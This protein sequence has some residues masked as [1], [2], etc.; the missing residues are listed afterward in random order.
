MRNVYT[1]CAITLLVLEST[2]GDVLISRA[3][4]KI[5]DLHELHARAGLWAVIKAILGS[6]TFLAGISCMALAFFS[7]LFAL[8][9]ADVSLVAPASAS[10]TFITNAVS[11]KS[12]LKERVDGRRWAAALCV[13][14]GVALLAS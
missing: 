10:L 1:W 11:A 13:A 12:L 3:M 8:S 5:G 14:A 7:L 4:K 9:W 6:S 2:A